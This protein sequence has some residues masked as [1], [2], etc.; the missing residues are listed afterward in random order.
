MFD[1]ERLRIGIISEGPTDHIVLEKMLGYFL[2]KFKLEIP[3][4]GIFPEEGKPGGW[5]RVLNYFVPKED[6]KEFAEVCAEENLL[7]VIQIDTDCCHEFGVERKNKEGKDKS[8]SELVAEVKA[9]LIK[10]INLAEDGLYEKNQYKIFF[11]ISVEEIEC[12]LLPFLIP[13]NSPVT[14]AQKTQGCLNAVNQT[15]DGFSLSATNKKPAFYT[16]IFDQRRKDFKKAEETKFYTQ[17]SAK[18][19]FESFRAFAGGLS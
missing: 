18:I 16:K 3:I 9:V 12:W 11:A 7:I 17:E 19:F 2:K 10:Q 15:L 13:Q 14:N 5:S 6:K 8:V 4:T 1:I